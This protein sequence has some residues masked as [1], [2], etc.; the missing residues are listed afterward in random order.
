MSG[1]LTHPVTRIIAELLIELSVGTSNTAEDWAVFAG[2]MPDQPDSCIRIAQ[3]ASRSDG[4][5][6]VTGRT[7]THPGVQ[8]MVRDPEQEDGWERANDIAI[9]LDTVHLRNVTIG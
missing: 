7:I 6:H 9:A 5:V 4:R 8:I 2:V 3:T 1:T